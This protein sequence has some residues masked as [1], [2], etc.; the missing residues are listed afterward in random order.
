M[1]AKKLL[2][3]FPI[4]I[5]EDGLQIILKIIL[6]LYISKS[7]SDIQNIQYAMKIERTQLQLTSIIFHLYKN[8]LCDCIVHC[9]VFNWSSAP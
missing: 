4:K 9:I 5:S 8:G 2:T 6:V 7:I 1:Y 3:S